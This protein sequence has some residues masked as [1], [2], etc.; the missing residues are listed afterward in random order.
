M[1]LKTV[2]LVIPNKIKNI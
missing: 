1:E 2:T